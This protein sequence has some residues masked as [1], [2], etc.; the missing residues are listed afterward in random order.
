MKKRILI[1]TFLFSI[2]IVGQ[3]FAA[4]STTPTPSIANNQIN[5]LKEKIASQVSKLNLVEKRGVIG[6]IEAVANNQITLTDTK[7]NIRYVDLDEITKFNSTGSGSSF[8]LSDLKKGMQISVLGIYNKD[9]Q[10]ILARFVTTVT[11]PTRYIG[12]I[13]AIDS[14]NFQVTI[15]TEDGKSAK[16]EIDTTSTV[17]SY[18]SGAD[19][20]KYGFS[21][22]NVGDRVTVVGYP[23]KKATLLIADRLI[24]YLNTPKDS[25][26]SIVTPTTAPTNAPTSA[27]AKNIK[28]LK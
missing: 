12:E 22:L 3:A 18:S 5:K 8:G 1:T 6:A 16:V 13:A 24:D 2:T 28:P 20:T 4:T 9:S 15:V 21:K 19:L 7:G 11:V 10:R 17:S 27:G 23:D 25:T 26:I 14:N